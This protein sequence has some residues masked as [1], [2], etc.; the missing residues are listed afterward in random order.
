MREIYKGK[1]WYIWADSAGRTWRKNIDSGD[2]WIL[3]KK[4]EWVEYRSAEQAARKILD[5][6]KDQAG[7]YTSPFI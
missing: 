6:M 7:I 3:N 5:D 2:T 1:E 4:G